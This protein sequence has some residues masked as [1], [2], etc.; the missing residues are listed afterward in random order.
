MRFETAPT[1]TK[2]LPRPNMRSAA[3]ITRSSCRSL[4]G[5]ATTTGEEQATE[6]R[7]VLSASRAG[8]L[9][10]CQLLVLRQPD[11]ERN[12]KVLR[13]R[14]VRRVEICDPVCAIY[15]VMKESSVG[16]PVL[17]HQHGRHPRSWLSFLEV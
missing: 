5:P 14:L 11:F 4:S 6:L 15:H 16:D 9:I 12:W 2:T 10:S 13:Q 7:A 17:G 8:T 3:S 1:H